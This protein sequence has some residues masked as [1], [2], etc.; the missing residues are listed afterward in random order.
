MTWNRQACSFSRRN[1]ARVL[2]T[3]ATKLL[4]PKIRGGGAPKR[5]NCPV[6]PRHASD[7][8]IRM[9]FGR[10]PRVQ[11][12]ALAFRR[13]TAALIRLLPLTQLRAAFLEPPGANGRTLPGASAAS[14]SRTGHSAGQA[15]P[16][17][18]PGAVCETARGHRACPAS[19]IASGMHP[20]TG[21]LMALLPELSRVSTTNEIA[22]G[23]F[24]SSGKHVAFARG[25]FDFARP[26][27][28]G[29]ASMHVTAEKIRWLTAESALR[30]PHP[31]R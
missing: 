11:R 1:R 4:P 30:S 24:V 10:R 3:K 22:R 8:A 7:V 21:R 17:S 12:N 31:T 16:R 23:A 25:V 28:A 6:G 14:S 26:G 29:S 20:S 9:R 5:R 2:P 13:S 19:Q 15:G 27:A 18:R